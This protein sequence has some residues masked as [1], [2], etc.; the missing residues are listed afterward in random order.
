[1][2]ADDPRVGT[3]L[4][5][6]YRVLE[7]LTAGSMGVVYRAERVKLNR[8][9][10][11]KVLH[12]SYATTEDGM[13]RFEVEARAMSRLS[14][15]NCVTVIDFGLDQG[16]PYLV[17]DFVTG[18]T[19][20]QVIA[21]EG[22]LAP[23][24]AVDTVRQ[25]LAGLG[26]AHAQG[27]IHR[28]VKPENIVIT[29]VE[30]QGEQVRILDF[31]LA[32]LRDEKT[33][34]TGVAVGTPGYMSPEQTVGE[35]VD[36]RADIYAVGI[37]LYELLVGRKPFRADTPFEIMRMH[38]QVPP[39]PLA[40]AAAD[41]TFSPALE[42]VVQRALAKSPGE[43]FSS[44][45]Q[46]ADA[47]RRTPEAPGVPGDRSRR[48][49]GIALAGVA[50][51]GIAVGVWSQSGIDAAQVDDAAKPATAAEG[52][53][54]IE[55]A[56]DDAPAVEPEAEA[57]PGAEAEDIA[58]LRAR[59]AAGEREEALRELDALRTR[60]PGRADVYYALG[61]ILTEMQRWS[62]AVHAYSVSL[63]LE[64]GYATDPRLIGDV[65]EALASDQAHER[66]ATVLSVQIVEPSLG[67]LESA[68]RSSN[69]TL[70]VR[71]A[72]VRARVAGDGED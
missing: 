42:A 60:E 8:K 25:I 28:D 71:A 63:T 56:E 32:K 53:E 10:A 61:N 44:A 16:A 24:R 6:R 67:R 20:R 58:A 19:L 52:I 2:A 54:A 57:E 23:G 11:I 72:E 47:L 5:D 18:R 4:H 12:E 26:H 37:I 55:P 31:G 30:G 62:A 3:L 17:M 51:F 27:I 36:E 46:F 38:R 48:T 22:R 64:P 41:L 65:V 70:R 35:I 1:M 49:I 39:A 50:A 33:V 59:A 68:T 21:E 13:R 40:H 66:A 43:R 29:V 9:V 34:T 69:P 7:R 15:P 14:H 45:A